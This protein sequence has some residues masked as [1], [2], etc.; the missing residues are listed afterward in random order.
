MKPISVMYLNEEASKEQLVYHKHSQP[1][2]QHLIRLRNKVHMQ[3]S[4]FR[5]KVE[6]P[7]LSRKK[8]D[9]IIFLNSNKFVAPYG[10]H[11]SV[12]SNPPFLY[13]L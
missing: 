13:S 11:Q 5:N 8:V 7:T 10:D 1:I 3:Y 12:S 2:L 6:K 4:Y 9:N